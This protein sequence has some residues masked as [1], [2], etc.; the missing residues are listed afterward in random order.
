[1]WL[2]LYLSKDISGWLEK[3]K[4]SWHSLTTSTI[5]T[6]TLGDYTLNIYNYQ[7]SLQLPLSFTGVFDT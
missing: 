7:V 3:I 5:L 2:V 6:N 4:I 1:M